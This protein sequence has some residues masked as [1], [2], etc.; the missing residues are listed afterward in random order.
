MRIA[1]QLALLAFVVLLPLAAEDAPSFAKDVAP[2]L[3]ANCAG[4]HAAK[5]KMGGLNVDTFEGLQAGGNK[6]S[7]LTAGK[8]DESRLYLMIAGKGAP[9]MPLGGKPLAMGDI[10]TIRKW[11]DAGAKLP[12]G[13]AR[14]CALDRPVMST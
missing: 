13:S 2:V 9:A 5:V 12:A 4:C 10:E 1:S 7:V 14:S 3:S 11:I 6:G 8:S